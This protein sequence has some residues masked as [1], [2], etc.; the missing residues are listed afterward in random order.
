MFLPLLLF[1]TAALGAAAAAERPF[2]N[3]V[4]TVN[5]SDIRECRLA[6]IFQTVMCARVDVDFDAIREDDEFYFNGTRFKKN[7]T[8]EPERMGV[9]LYSF[10]VRLSSTCFRCDIERASLI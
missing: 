2:I 3:I 1:G 5:N 4:K 9:A 8:M 6:D 10:M 7:E